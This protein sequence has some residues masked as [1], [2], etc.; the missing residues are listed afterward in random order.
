MSRMQ[1]DPQGTARQGHSEE[2]RRRLEDDLKGTDRGQ[3]ANKRVD[4]YLEQAV[5]IK[6]E[7]DDKMRKRRKGKAHG[8]KRVT[9]EKGTMRR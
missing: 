3:A 4:E 2:C 5:T 6:V 8:G 7:K 1:F 9:K